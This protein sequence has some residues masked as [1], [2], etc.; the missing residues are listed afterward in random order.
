MYLWK[1]SRSNFISE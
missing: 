1:S